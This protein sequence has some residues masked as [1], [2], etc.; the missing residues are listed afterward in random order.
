MISLLLQEYE[1]Q[2][3]L[4]VLNFRIRSTVKRIKKFYCLMLQSP[5]NKKYQN[6]TRNQK[7]SI[8]R[9]L[10]GLEEFDKQAERHKLKITIIVKF[11]LKFCEFVQK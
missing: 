2:K 8:E 11:F 3:A 5:K 1:R 10:Y 4:P 7:N 6:S 9:G